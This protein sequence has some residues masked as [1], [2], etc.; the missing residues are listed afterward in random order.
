MTTTEV[1]G[2]GFGTGYTKTRSRGRPTA[3]VRQLEDD[4]ELW[5]FARIA[6]ASQLALR[7]DDR[8]ERADLRRA[9]ALEQA[10]LE[11]LK[12]RSRS[13]T[14]GVESAKERVKQSR[15]FNELI[16]QAHSEARK[17]LPDRKPGW[18]AVLRALGKMEGVTVRPNNPRQAAEYDGYTR[19]RHTI[20]NQITSL[21]QA[22]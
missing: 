4:E 6:K 15:S 8:V 19:A 3:T 7:T 22:L 1:A 10:S 21:N 13:V 14:L 17:E 12:R 2:F 11:G 9:I 20:Q 18:R 5:I 16:A